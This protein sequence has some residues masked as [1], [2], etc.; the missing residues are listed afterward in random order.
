M[1]GERIE[2]R[3]RIDFVAEE[4]DADRFFIGR[5]RINLDHVAAHTESAA[6][7]IHVVAL[8]EHVDQPAEHGFAA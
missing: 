4:F 5:R 7:E 1:S 2:T 6:R 8:V 3:D